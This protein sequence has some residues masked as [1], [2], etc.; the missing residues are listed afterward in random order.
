MNLERAQL[1][2][3]DVQT[4]AETLFDSEIDCGSDDAGTIGAAVYHAVIA[5]LVGCAHFDTEHEDRREAIGRQYGLMVIALC[6]LTNTTD[7]RH[8]GATDATM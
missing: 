6:H 2:A 4:F 1:L 8:E 7:E 3:A 5:A